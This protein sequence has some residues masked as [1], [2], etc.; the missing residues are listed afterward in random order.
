MNGLLMH[1]KDGRYTSYDDVCSVPVPEATKSYQPLPNETLI[2]LVRDAIK[3]RIGYPIIDETYGLSGKD[4]QMFG[5]IRVG[6]DS[7]ETGL[8]IG[9]R[10]DYGKMLAAAIAGGAYVFVCDNLCF[11]GE[12]VTVM[13]KHTTHI[14]RDLPAL[15]SHAMG[16]C[17]VAFERMNEQLEAMKDVPVSLDAG[18]GGI[19][20]ALGYGL[21]KPQQATIAIN[22]WRTPRH[23]E[24]SERNLY[25]LYN[26]YTEGLKKGSAGGAI[27]RLSS[28]HDWVCELLPGPT[29]TVAV[30]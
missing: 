16:K 23:E 2:G 10:N 7:S 8:S 6:L 3:S 26:C 12:Y 15:V 30:A 20:R 4:Q 29:T 18:Y 25:S 1:T 19:G 14:L 5:V 17:P 21:L 28:L 27:G 11:S 22:D 24:F 13:R 9:L